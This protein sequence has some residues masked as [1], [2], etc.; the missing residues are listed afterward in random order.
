MYL[1]YWVKPDDS[2]GVEEIPST[3]DLY[4]FTK[5]NGYCTPDH[6]VYCTVKEIWGAYAEVKL[7]HVINGSWKRFP[8]GRVP[9]A[10][11]AFHLLT[12]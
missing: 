4:G 7:A 8:V 6:Y 12:Q 2:V 3:G 11:R 1:I 5:R 10:I 9:P